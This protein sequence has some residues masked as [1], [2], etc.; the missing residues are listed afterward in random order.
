MR[1]LQ[2][3]KHAADHAPRHR[4]TLALAAAAF[5]LP[6]AVLA[7]AAAPAAAASQPRGEATLPTV[8]VQAAAPENDYQADVVSSPKFTQAI[9]D[10]PQTITVIKK[11]LLQQEQATTLTEALRNTP[12]VTLQ[13]GENGSTQT[14]DSIYLRGFD[15]SQ[16]IFVDGIRDLGAVSR[17]MFNIDQVEVVKGPSGSDIGRGAS[18]AYINLVSKS[19]QPEARDGRPEH[20]AVGDQRR[21]PERD[22]AG[23]RRPRP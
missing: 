3:R 6:G 19:A 14:G 7:Q 9:V 21:A 17:D 4:S 16:S 13:L 20:A 23:L 12:G 1:T 11:E 2:S 10:T 22:G 5:A 15:S 8:K 18:S